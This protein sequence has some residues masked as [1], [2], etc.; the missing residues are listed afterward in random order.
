MSSSYCGC[1]PRPSSRTPV[2]S[3]GWVCPPSRTCSRC[4]P[5]DRHAGAHLREKE[6]Q[7]AVFLHTSLPQDSVFQ[8]AELSLW[9]KL[10]CD[11]GTLHH[12]SY[13]RGTDRNKWRRIIFVSNLLSCET[14][15]SFDT[16]VQTPNPG[17]SLYHSPKHCNSSSWAN[18]HT[19]VKWKAVHQFIES[20][21][22]M[23][24]SRQ[25]SKLSLNLH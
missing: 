24:S 12:W 20:P 16:A 5:E 19:C 14:E 1:S 15:S 6:K 11:F 3:A 22:T 9:S 4:I 10:S 18:A 2:C 21:N 25:Q 13:Q 7:N 8:K 23:P 17:L